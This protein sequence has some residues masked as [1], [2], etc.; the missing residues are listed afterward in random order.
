MLLLSDVALCY[1]PPDS[2]SVA[3]SGIIVP[4]AASKSVTRDDNPCGAVAGTS[5]LSMLIAMLKPA[6]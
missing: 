1:Y 6:F 2:R 4:M 5:N 3:V